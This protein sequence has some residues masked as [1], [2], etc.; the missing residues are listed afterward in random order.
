VKVYLIGSL[1]N[2]KVP[3][4]AQ[5]LREHD[6]EVFDDWFAAGPEAD[7]KW[8]EY[9][10]SRGHSYLEALDGLAADHVFNF[11][12]SHLDSSDA[13]VLVLPAGKSGHL[14][15]GYAIGTGKP[16]YI[17]ID[18]PE[19]WDVMY[20]F[21]TKVFDKVDELIQEFTKP[22]VHWFDVNNPDNWG[23]F[24]PLTGVG[25]TISVGSGASSS[26]TYKW[27]SHNLLYGPAADDGTGHCQMC[28]EQI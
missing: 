17:L 9:E 11:D 12:K 28:G 21:A 15:L 2:P 1:R 16:G 19:R 24:M 8:R 13:V 18:D 4:I 23:T 6:L 10:K 27:C 5:K 3:E 7:D 22:P 26:V 25:G 20:R 14:E